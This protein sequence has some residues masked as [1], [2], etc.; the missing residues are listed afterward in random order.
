VA[1]SSTSA[2]AKTFATKNGKNGSFKIRT[3]KKVEKTRKR[4]DAHGKP[5]YIVLCLLFSENSAK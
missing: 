3:N 5:S 1:G 2:L 4:L